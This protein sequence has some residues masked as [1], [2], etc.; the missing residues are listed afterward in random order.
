[1][2]VTVS[3][4]KLNCIPPLRCLALC[5]LEKG[6]TPEEMSLLAARLPHLADIADETKE[7]FCRQLAREN[8]DTRPISLLARAAK[9]SSEENSNV[10]K[11]LV[12][13]H[14]EL[15][16]TPP[17]IHRIHPLPTLEL[18]FKIEKRIEKL[19]FIDLWNVFYKNTKPKKDFIPSRF[20]ATCDWN[21]PDE[22]IQKIRNWILEVGVVKRVTRD[23]F[24]AF[25][26]LPLISVV[27]DLFLKLIDV[28]SD[29]G[30][31]LE[32]SVEY[33]IPDIRSTL[34]RLD[35]KQFKQFLFDAARHQNKTV[36][37]V[38]FQ[39]AEE[40]G[41][42]Y[43]L[44][45]QEVYGLFKCS[46]YPPEYKLSSS[47]PKKEVP[48]QVRY[49]LFHRCKAGLSPAQISELL[50]VFPRD[51]PNPILFELLRLPQARR[52][53][54]SGSGWGRF[55]ETAFEVLIERR[56][57]GSSIEILHR[58]DFLKRCLS[59]ETI[60]KARADLTKQ[61]A[62]FGSLPEEQ[63]TCAHTI[64]MLRG[65]RI[66]V[67]YLTLLEMCFDSAV[68]TPLAPSLS[69]VSHFLNLHKIPSVFRSRVMSNIDLQ[70]Q[71]LLIGMRNSLESACL[72][73]DENAQ[74]V[75]RQ[76]LRHIVLDAVFEKDSG[77]LF[78]YFRLLQPENIEPLSLQLICNFLSE[79]GSLDHK[80]IAVLTR[81]QALLAPAE[82]SEPLKEKRAHEEDGATP[83]KKPCLD[84]ELA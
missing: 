61:I 65:L 9:E 81:A 3:G 41:E 6:E 68:D 37:D 15:F 50:H 69:R 40:K 51:L 5:A 79:K 53:P 16:L 63:K 71:M 22:H 18:L 76:L 19:A 39:I 58:L 35:S 7:F 78:Q 12:E 47:A 83:S 30:R 59:F 25:P 55:L 54:S 48:P 74:H 77:L 36:L 52:V 13:W 17:L 4:L 46:L 72:E 62:S 66:L 42:M 23:P 84:P 56:S 82:P 57:I 1:M 49:W 44:S 73:K 80:E 32:S 34:E 75:L 24:S 31:K 45:Q 28:D 8:S 27:K 33:F 2:T 70:H 64:G 29:L 38:G 67:D 10:W 43:A 21:T 20:S 11:R 60:H 26:D 14:N